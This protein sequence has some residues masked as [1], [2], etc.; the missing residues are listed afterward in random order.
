MENR[1][2]CGWA[3][4]AAV[5]CDGKRRATARRR[6]VTDI[7]AAAMVNTSGSIRTSPLHKHEADGKAG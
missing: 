1:G 3:R 7:A 4:A 6:P 5:V 2:D